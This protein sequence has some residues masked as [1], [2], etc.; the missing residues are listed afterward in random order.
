MAFRYSA[1]LILALPLAACVEDNGSKAA[2]A[3]PTVGSSSDLS[4]FEGAR[5][6]QAEMGIQTLGFDLIRSEGLT[7]WW[8]NLSTGACARITT[9]NG[10]YSGVTM[11]PAGD[12]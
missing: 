4:S 8:F 7:S 1:L 10:V 6:G 12:C 2:T 5:A 11:L 3:T 9:S